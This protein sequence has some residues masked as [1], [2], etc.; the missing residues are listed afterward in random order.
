MWIL[1]LYYIFFFVWQPFV[2]CAMFRVMTLVSAADLAWG[3]LW[4][5]SIE[6][7]PTFRLISGVWV[8]TQEIWQDSFYRKS[9]I[10]THIPEHDT[11]RQ[12]GLR[13]S[14]IQRSWR[15]YGWQHP[16]RMPWGRKRKRSLIFTR[17]TVGLIFTRVSSSFGRTTRV[18]IGPPLLNVMDSW[19]LLKTEN[20][21][22]REHNKSFTVEDY[23]LCRLEQ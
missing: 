15:P 5:W 6:S 18:S 17:L 13:L 22:I 14:I 4:L 7:P 12:G 9:G 20:T 21:R 23:L 8:I 10:L 16:L 1:W 2:L 11:R 3:S 19:K